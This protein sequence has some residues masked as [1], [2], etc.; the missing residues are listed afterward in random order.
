MLLKL[1]IYNK[2]N[3]TK[4]YTTES[5][6]IMFGTVEDLLNL[7]DLEKFNNS[8]NDMEFIKVVTEAVVK[9]FDIIKPLLKDIFEGLTDDELRNTKISEIVN[10]LVSIIKI[11]MTQITSGTKTKN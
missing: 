7:I 11:T 1:N 2:K 6:D 5:Y 3:I 4:T 9:G 10:I 8:K